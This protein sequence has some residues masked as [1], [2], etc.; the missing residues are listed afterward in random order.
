MQAVG[1]DINEVD[2]GMIILVRR[3]GGCSSLHQQTLC[4]GIFNL[5]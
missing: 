5:Y 2:E 1:E 3:P 4:E